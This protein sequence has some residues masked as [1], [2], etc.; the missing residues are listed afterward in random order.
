MSG[1]LF[2]DPPLAAATQAK[3][4]IRWYGDTVGGFDT[5]SDMWLAPNGST[6]VDDAFAA[7]FGFQDPQGVRLPGCAVPP[8]NTPYPWLSDISPMQNGTVPDLVVNINDVFAIL[9]A[10]Q[11][12]EYPGSDLAQCP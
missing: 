9:L 5:D 12:A 7:I 1:S 3:P 2:S 8:C 4:G 10:F 11:V 6:N